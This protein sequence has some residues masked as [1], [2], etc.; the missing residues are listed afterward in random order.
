MASL[1][2]ISSLSILRRHNE[3][4]T[5]INDINKDFQEKNIFEKLSTI[6]KEIGKE[7]ENKFESI[8]EGSL[9]AF[10]RI[11]RDP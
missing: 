8:E 3:L 10:R 1:Q 7:I 11:Q 2:K 4:V 9:D 5:S 6:T